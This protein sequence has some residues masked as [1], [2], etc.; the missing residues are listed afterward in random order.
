MESVFLLWEQSLTLQSTVKNMVGSSDMS[1][2]ADEII[3][4]DGIDFA[5]LE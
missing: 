4:L 2:A 1:S 3:G 5:M